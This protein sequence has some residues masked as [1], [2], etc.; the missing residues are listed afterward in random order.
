[1]ASLVIAGDSSGSITV[2]APSAAGSTVITLPAQTGTATVSGPAFSAY[3]SANQTVTSGTV[4]LLTLNTESFDT[5]SCF[6]NT[7]STVGG[8]PAYAF[9]PNEAGYY[10]INFAVGSNGTSSLTYAGSY[11]YKNGSQIS[12]NITPAYSGNNGET[13]NVRLIYMNGTTDYL[14]FYGQAVGTG[15]V[16][17]T[18]VDEWRTSASAC[19]VR[20]A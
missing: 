17:I 16:T 5:A 2:S 3:L 19:F 13:M 14:Q 12:R 9:L 7:G 18:G 20:P 1:M 10:Q 4:T 15:T 11:V 8:I 6:N